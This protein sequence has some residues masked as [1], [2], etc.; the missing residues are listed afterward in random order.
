LAKRNEELEA[1][2]WRMKRDLE[3][4]ARI[5]KALLP[6]APPD[7]HGT[8]FAWNFK[9]CTEL[10]GDLLNVVRLDDKHVGLYV[11]DVVGHGVPAALLAVTVSHALARLHL[12][13]SPGSLAADSATGHRLPSPAQVAAQL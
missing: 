8:R 1:A 6:A 9:P 2:N 10:A 11:L 12:G 5:Q 4:A 7:A 3:A 13:P